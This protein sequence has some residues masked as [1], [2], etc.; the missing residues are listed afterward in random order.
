MRLGTL[1]LRTVLMGVLATSLFHGLY[2]D[3]AVPSDLKGVIE[4]K[5]KELEVVHQQIKEVHENLSGVQSEKKTLQRELGS[6]TS[7][8]TKLNLGIKESQIQIQKLSSEASALQYEINDLKI[9]I[10]QKEEALG[11]VL[12]D[13]HGSDREPPLFVLLRT[14]SLSESL[15]DVESLSAINTS[16][17]AAVDDL[18]QLQGELDGTLGETQDK[19]EQK[20]TEQGRLQAKKSIVAEEKEMKDSLLRQ[21]KNTEAI[22]QKQLSTLEQKQEKI[23]KEIDDLERQLRASF[24]NSLLSPRR[25]TF[26]SP[27]RGGVLTQGYGA[28]DFAQRAYRTKFHNGIDYGVSVG[29]PIYAV[30]DGKV[31]AISN[32]DRGSSRF[33]RFQYGKH[34]LLSHDNNLTTLYAH[35]SQ[36]NLV[37]IGQSVKRGDLIGYSGNTGYATGPHLHFGVYW[38]P[39]IKFKSV[40]PAAGLVPVGVTVNPKDYL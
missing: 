7:S 18:K 35:L 5:A 36:N 25:G 9:K 14:K 13:M 17:Y 34:I 31:F 26:I 28:T 20:A 8:I 22:Y 32:N 24:D 3:A 39:S 19:K 37:S 16:L 4:Q 11:A 2:S 40:P 38:T 15:A 21:T 10:Q 27:I 23:G 30:A 12:R 29:T 33:D 1:L 6:I